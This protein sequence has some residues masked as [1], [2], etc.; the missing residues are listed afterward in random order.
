MSLLI[1]ISLL[2]GC[3]NRRELNDMA[4]VVG[5]GVDKS[6]GQYVVTVQVVNPGEVASRKGASGRTPVTTYSETGAHLFEAVRRM[7][8]ITPRRLYFSH[9]QMFVIS[10][11]LAREGISKPLE[12]L[13]RDHE[14]RQDFYV[15]VTKQAKAKDILSTLTSLEKLPASKM[16]SSLKTSEE[17][18]APTAAIT[19]DEL[20]SDLTSDGKNP[21]LTGIT[22]TGDVPAGRSIRNMESTDIPT[23]L[24]YEDIAVFKKDKLVGWLNE[25][26][27]KGYNY[28][29]N[30]V[31]STVGRTA[32]P[33]GGDLVVEI[34]RS[35]ADVKG[36][37][38]QGEPVID[39]HLSAE[40]NISEVACHVD[41]TDPKTITRIEELANQTSEEILQASVEKAKSLKSDIFGFGEVIRRADPQAWK[42][43]KK[44]W[45][46]RFA[47]A[48]VHIQSEFKIRRTGIVN[49]SFLDKT[50][51]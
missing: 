13:S 48:P 2:T 47:K 49:R 32:C 23:K 36:R 41:L 18:W 38:D 12:F 10:E 39:I 50:E 5:M 37:L 27:S 30:N 51:E 17:A 15:V 19:L 25:K 16:R 29:R 34:V 8:K 24:K 35:K 26:E 22:L 43:M 3:W 14:F 9:L 40:A 42:K 44:D 4:L 11:E 21:V 20:I 46:T 33:D 45:D 31:Q 1:S 6:E 28:I 7:T